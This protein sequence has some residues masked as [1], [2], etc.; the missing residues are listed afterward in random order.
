MYAPLLI[1]PARAAR[2]SE[3]LAI[4]AELE[5]SLRLHA[6]GE[7]FIGHRRF[8][9]LNGRDVAGLTAAI[10]CGKSIS[11]VWLWAAVE[12]AS[13]T[14]NIAVFRAAASNKSLVVVMAL[15]AFGMVVVVRGR[16]RAGLSEAAA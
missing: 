7:L 14:A 2:I 4:V 11:W 6:G 10:C 12:A 9:G 1:I 3:Y 8:V 15:V 5:A 16:D 13:A